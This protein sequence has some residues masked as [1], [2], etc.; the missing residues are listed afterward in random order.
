MHLIE[1]YLLR[2]LLGP[3]I[4]AVVALS[5]V[6]ML[7][8][9]LGAL[10][11]IVNQGQS[12][13]VLLKLTLLALPQL[14]VMVLPIAIFV[15]ALVALN[16]LHTEQEIVVCFAS[17][18]SRWRVI[19][20]AMRLAAV[21][22]VF[23]LF[24]N[25]WIEPLAERGIRE[26]LFRVRTDLA[27]SLVRVGEFSE[28]A[29]GLTV[30]AQGSD[31]GGSFR[32]L[33]VIQ[34]KADGGDTTFFAARG[35][36]T[37]RDGSPV[38]I[39]RDGSEQ[40]FSNAGVLDYLTFHEYVFAL[41]DFLSKSEIIHYKI[42]DRYMHELLFPDLTQE[43]E[44]KARVEMLAEFNAR[45]ATP[46]YNIAFMAMALAAVIGGSFSRLGYGKRIIAVGAGAAVVRIIGFAVLA[47]CAHQAWANI[48]QY[49]TPLA[50]TGWAFHELFRQ[51]VT[52]FVALRPLTGSTSPMGARA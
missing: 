16:R 50:A 26:E 43:W 38:L 11:I 47:V 41:S 29:P 12:A 22:T 7:S 52:R 21:A 19:S 9:S 17:G 1:R 28:P 14:L 51:R 39:M 2:Q 8:Q 4:L 5:I 24:L 13:F 30:Y 44:R 49:L 10:D 48:L 35:K 20:P 27:A 3:T 45:L 34:E 25:L 23:S 31:A 6:A 15:A 37:K 40:S 33:F 36:V 42:S 18:M 46:L 32:N